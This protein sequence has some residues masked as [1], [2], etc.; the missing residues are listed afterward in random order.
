MSVSQED[1]EEGARARFAAC[2]SSALRDGVNILLLIDGLD[3]KGLVAFSEQVRDS[4]Q[5]NS[6][7]LWIAPSYCRTRRVA[8]NPQSSILNPK[9]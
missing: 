9:P 3:E 7:S 5:L 4:A 1:M 8:L 6:H 2:L